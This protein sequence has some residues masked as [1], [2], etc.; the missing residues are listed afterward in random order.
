MA[1]PEDEE[2]DW[3]QVVAIM[4]EARA[5]S[6]GYASYWEWA[7]NRSLAEIGVARALA[8]YLTH[9]EERT[10]ASVSPIINDPPDVLLLCTSGERLG[11]EVTELVDADAIKRHRHRK[12]TDTAEAYDWADWTIERLT[13]SIVEAVERKD[14]KL[15]SRAGQYDEL[16][17]AIATD[18]PLISLELAR[19]AIQ[20]SAPSV[21][22]VHRAFLLLSYNPAAD[23]VTFPEGI[24]VF[25]IRLQT[26][27]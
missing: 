21:H 9:S 25:P 23:K 5:K 2:P 15:A 3:D 18:E 11:I 7:P 13:S 14:R 26:L 19:Q 27:P 10:W 17:V 4:R 22:T 24:P 16:I 12:M 6:R 8:E 1:D 20:N